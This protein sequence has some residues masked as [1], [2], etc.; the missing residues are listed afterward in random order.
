MVFFR[1]ILILVVLLLAVDFLAGAVLKHFY[2]RQKSGIDYQTIYSVEKANEDILF[3][4]SSRA[5]H[6]YVPDIFADKYA[7]SAYNTGRD[8]NYILYGYCLAKCIFE[9]HQPKLAIIDVSRNEFQR[10]EGSYDYLSSLLPFYGNYESIRDIIDKRSRFEPVK[11]FF[12]TYPYNSLFP[13]IALNVIREKSKALNIKGYIPLYRSIDR[14]AKVISK[15]PDYELDPYLVD[16]FRQFIKKCKENGIAV[17]VVCSPYFDKYEQE[18][19]TL[20]KVKE[21]CS[22][23]SV[24]FLDYS[25]DARFTGNQKKFDDYNHLNNDAAKEYSAICSDTLRIL[26]HKI[27]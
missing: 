9:R 5:A 13:V 23:E 24:T 10:K 12:H 3:F 2:F 18:D 27:N 7:M 16:T 11:L 1:K 20:I 8:G 6:H 17:A 26:Q 21:I 4:G 19:A 22:E 25:Q 15:E 14:P